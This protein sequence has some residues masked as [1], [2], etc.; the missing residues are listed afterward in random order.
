M[1]KMAKKKGYIYNMSNPKYTMC[2]F[3]EK[4]QSIKNISPTNHY[5]FSLPTFSGTLVISDKKRNREYLYGI[6]YCPICG[7]KVT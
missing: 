5:Q 3:C 1:S 7:R 4:N 6:A 2:D